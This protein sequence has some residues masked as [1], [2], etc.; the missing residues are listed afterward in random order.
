MEGEGDRLDFGG[1]DW[2]VGI[3]E[4]SE[5]YHLLY[6]Q[7]DRQRTMVK[8][9]FPR[10]C[11]LVEETSVQTLCDTGQD[12]LI[13]INTQLALERKLRYPASTLPSHYRYPF[14]LPFQR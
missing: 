3:E 10:S 8:D 11:G 4:L 5:A 14:T 2:G 13:D 9:F 6:K 7:S 12:L 1:G